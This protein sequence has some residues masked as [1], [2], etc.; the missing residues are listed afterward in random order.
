MLDHAPHSYEQLA[1]AFKG[2]PEDGLTR[3]EI[4]VDITL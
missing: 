1:H 2:H 3:D 4:L